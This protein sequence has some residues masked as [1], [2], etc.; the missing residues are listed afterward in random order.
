M[1]GGA[2]SATVGAILIAVPVFQLLSATAIE[3]RTGRR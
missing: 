1:S 2:R 3:T